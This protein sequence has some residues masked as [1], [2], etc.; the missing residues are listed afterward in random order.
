[1]SARLRLPGRGLSQRGLDALL[2]LIPHAHLHP[3]T[4]SGAAQAVVLAAGYPNVNTYAWTPG[5]GAFPRS[6]A[7]YRRPAVTVT[8]AR[9]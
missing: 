7:G 4:A 6:R 8:C 5:S 1:M 3:T 9:R 2:E